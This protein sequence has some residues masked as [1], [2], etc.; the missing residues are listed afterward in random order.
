[1]TEQKK[2]PA[3]KKAAT[4]KKAPAKSEQ[5]NAPSST[6]PDDDGDEPTTDDD[7]A[8]GTPPT[9]VDGE[10]KDEKGSH[11]CP[12]C[13]RRFPRES[14]C[15]GSPV[16]PHPPIETAPTSELSKDAKHHTAA[17]ASE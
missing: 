1:M 9:V 6:E 10:V 14:T 3:K 8:E 17:P 16:A 13:G 15:T 5:K 2:A 11:Y 4:K 7:G 12:G